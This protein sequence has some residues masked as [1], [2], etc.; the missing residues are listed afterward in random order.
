MQKKV[1]TL[2]TM[3]Q[4][5]AEVKNVLAELEPFADIRFLQANESLS[6]YTEDLEV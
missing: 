3:I 2:I 6:K 1:K 5:S 4:P